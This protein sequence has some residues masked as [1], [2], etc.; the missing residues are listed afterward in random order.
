MNIEGAGSVEFDPNSIRKVVS[1]QASQ[2]VAWRVFTE[3]MGAWWPLAYYKIGK[4]NAVDAVIEP[5]IGGRWYERGDD[6]SM[7][8]WGSVIA[9]EPHSR[10]VLSWDINAD[11]QYDPTLK[12][13]I[14]VRFNAD[15][16]DRTRVELEHRHLD[17][18]GAR[19]DEMR[20]IYDTEGDWGKILEMF[21]RVAA[22]G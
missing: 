19:R 7:C 11:W 10:L 12:T 8:Q 16:S 22:E 21:A 18:Y 4:A 6:G 1:V 5:R 3:K 13:E 20:R 17:R 9:W 15:G 2:A 14:E